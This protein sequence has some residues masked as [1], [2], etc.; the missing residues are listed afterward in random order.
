MSKRYYYIDIGNATPDQLADI[1]AAH[2]KEEKRMSYHWTSEAVGPGHPDKVADQI[3]DAVLDSYLEQDPM[4]KVACETL[5]KGKTVVLAGEI[6]SRGK[7]DIET[8]VRQTIRDI[9][10]Q[11]ERFLG[12]D[13]ECKIV[14]LLSEQSPEINQAVLGDGT[15]TGAG[16]QGIM[17]GYADAAGPQQMPLAI[18]IAR[19][20]IQIAQ[21][22]TKSSVAGLLY[23]D[24]KSQVTLEYNEHGEPE[25]ISHIVLSMHHHES[26]DLELLRQVYHEAM[27]PR[28]SFDAYLT[29]TTQHHINP[30]GPWTF[31]GPAADAGLTGRKIVAD[32][33][34]AD[35]Q[36]GG[37]AFSGKD[38]TKVDRSAA[39][40]A[41]HIAKNIVAYG[42]AAKAK[43]QLS[44]AIGEA[45]PISV[46]VDTMGTHRND[47][48]D[49]HLSDV[50]AGNWD[51]SP[52]GIM[53]KFG[54]YKP[55]FRPT[56]AQ[57]H[58]GFKPQSLYNGETGW[59]WEA[60][61]ADFL[62]RI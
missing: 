1:I 61:D 27:L 59:T 15:E 49:S 54:L 24:C 33:Y 31:G 14:N 36:I 23:P 26:I 10:Y 44:Y 50:A 57:G 7:I 58:F 20:L 56:A 62:T 45:H 13:E 17:F 2:N 42:L 52:D 21:S 46:R 16:D 30:A 51:L 53:R 3:S 6:T 9:G 22:T 8:A 4:S 43:V 35:C 48:T 29:D 37:G 40:A 12:F 32:N 18:S 60:T 28:L 19:E 5:V 11:S 25:R 38:P 41:R 34:G 39:Y 47:L 55:I